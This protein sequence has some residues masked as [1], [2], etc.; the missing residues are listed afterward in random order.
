MGAISRSTTAESRSSATERGRISSAIS[1]LA[2]G[3]ARSKPVAQMTSP[4]TTTSTE[5]TRSAKTSVA[6]PRRLRLPLSDRRRMSSEQ[7]LAS[8]ATPAKTTIG[9]G[10][11]GLR[12]GQPGDAGV[13][14]V[15]TDAQEHRGVEQGRQDLGAVPAEGRARSGRAGGDVR[16]S[17]REH[18]PGRVG[19]HVGGVG[20]QRQRAREPGTHQ[21]GHQ[22]RAG[23]DQHQQ[24][25]APVL[26]PA[27]GVAV[28]V[29]HV[30]SVD[31]A[32]LA[33]RSVSAVR[34]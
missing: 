6:A 3:S 34:R 18:D 28:V 33:A 19:G 25:P 24:Q 32:A 20:E 11:T 8:I 31:V 4:A 13:G 5:P 30:L 17:Q 14:E 12:V 10:S 22:H 29:A 16:R 1:R 26:G 23:D 21:L 2:I 27:R 9:T 7:P 15:G